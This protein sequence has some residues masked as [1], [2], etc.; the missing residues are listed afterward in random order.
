MRYG[1]IIVT[2]LIVLLLSFGIGGETRVFDLI[3]YFFTEEGKE[4][5][6]GL[7]AEESDRIL[8]VIRGADEVKVEEVKQKTRIDQPPTPFNTTQFIR[9]AGRI[10]MV[11][12][13]AMNVAESL[14]TAGYVTYP[15]TDNTVYQKS[16]DC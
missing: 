3:K 2:C 12:K 6:R 1:L 15:R 13:R 9:A 7:S 8:G 11:A 16:L 4:S 14:Y 10:G 5:E